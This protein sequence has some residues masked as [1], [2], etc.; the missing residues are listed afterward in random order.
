M[1]DRL[2]RA[3]HHALEGDQEP[4]VRGRQPTLETL[5]PGDVVSL[6][7]GGDSVVQRVLE[8]SEVL[9]GRVT[10]WRWSL[11]DGDRLLEAGPDGHV[12]YGRTRILHQTTPEFEVLTSAPEQGGLLRTFEARVREGVA[13]REPVVFTLDGADY[14]ITSTGTFSARSVGAPTG[15]PPYGGAEVWR[16]VDPSDASQNVYAVLE[17]AAETAE[18][19]VMLAVWTTHIALL[20]GRGL[21]DADVQ[22]IYPGSEGE[23]THG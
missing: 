17:P 19:S 3:M 1:F 2:S 12:L 5:L 4:M 8:C 21:T 7:D 15:Q 10:Q 18:D 16:D 13:A 22:S 9:N 14:R 23:A 20:F 6:W 11:L